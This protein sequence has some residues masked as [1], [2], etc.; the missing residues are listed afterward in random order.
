[1]AKPSCSAKIA[2]LIIGHRMRLTTKPAL[3]L[4]PIGVLP[5]RSTNAVAASI[6]A[7]ELCRPRMISTSPITGTGLKKCMPR[8]RSGCFVAQ[9]SRVIEIDEVFVA[10]SA[11]GRTTVSM[12]SRIFILTVSFSVAASTTRSAGAKSFGSVVVRIRAITAALSASLIVS[13]RTRRSSDPEIVFMPRSSAAGL[14]SCMI[15][16]KP[17]AAPAGAMPLPIVPEPMTPMVWMFMS[18]PCARSRCDRPRGRAAS[19]SRGSCR[20]AETVQSARH[21]A[22]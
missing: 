9:A 5:R 12:F 21:S 13:L 2:S 1:V 17:T 4:T 11:S 6:V 20:R 22:G 8:K 3:F 7:S 14:T 10:I 16:L 18:F 15:T 19:M